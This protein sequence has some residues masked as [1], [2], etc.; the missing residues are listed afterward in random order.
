[1]DRGHGLLHQPK[2]RRPDGRS[3]LALRS[4]QAARLL[5]YVEFG[6][7]RDATSSAC[8]SIGGPARTILSAKMGGKPHFAADPTRVYLQFADGPQRR[9]P[10]HRPAA[11]RGLD[12]RARL[13]FHRRPGQRR[14]CP[15]RPDG[16]HAL[17][18]RPAAPSS[19]PAR[20]TEGAHRPVQTL[21]DHRRLTDVGADFFGW[22]D[23]EPH[24][25]LVCRLHLLSPA[26]RREDAH[27]RS[28]L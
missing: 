23:G 15:H 5:T 20:R 8:P 6:N 17:I 2:L 12:R 4:P 14:R 21:A 28:R 11:A 16:K 9:R 3:V 27:R 18:D 24:D 26:D 7:Q 10:R 25:P 13:L 1:M 19:R 22:A